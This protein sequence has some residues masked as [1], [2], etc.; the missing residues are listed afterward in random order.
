MY[1]FHKHQ[2]GMDYPCPKTISTTNNLN[3][4]KNNETYIW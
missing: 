2:F 3:Y 4:D 1:S